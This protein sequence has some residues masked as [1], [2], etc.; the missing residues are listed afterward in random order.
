MFFKYKPPKEL[1]ALF[2]AHYAP[3]LLIILIGPITPA[4]K[5]WYHISLWTIPTPL[6][7]TVAAGIIIFLGGAVF[8]L[9]WEAFWHKTYNGQ[10]VTTGFFKYIRH[11]HYTSLLIISI[12]LALFFYSTAALLLAL[13]SIPILIWSIL[14]EEKHLIK[15]Y[16][17]EYK[18]YMKKVKWRMIP[19]L[20]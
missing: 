8:Y 5:I 13:I 12:G 9:K 15:Q 16:G 6:L 1:R 18:D 2:I 19:R 7:P 17:R 14:D 11:P 4:L 3:L 10:L 20:F